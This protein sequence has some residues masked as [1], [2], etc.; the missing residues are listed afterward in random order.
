MELWPGALPLLW[1][2]MVLDRHWFIQVLST[3]TLITDAFQLNPPSILFLAISYE[4]VG[5]S[6]LDLMKHWSLMG[7]WNE[8]LTLGNGWQFRE[9]VM[10]PPH[11]QTQM[12]R[13]KHGNE[14]ECSWTEEIANETDW[15]IKPNKMKVQDAWWLKIWPKDWVWVWKLEIYD[16]KWCIVDL[17][18]WLKW[19]QILGDKQALKAW[20][21][22]ENQKLKD[23]DYFTL[24]N[25]V[26]HN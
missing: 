4:L 23:L 6:G 16:E 25:C 21:S 8:V 3:L 13:R 10:N 11:Y 19:R 5:G 20:N 26:Q 22:V 14:Q 12:D 18:W 9:S 15:P 1:Y 7:L 2:L 17:S 24:K